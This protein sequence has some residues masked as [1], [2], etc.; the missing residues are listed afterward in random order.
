MWLK[1]L[2][3]NKW[4]L[5][6]LVAWVLVYFFVLPRVINVK[7]IVNKQNCEDELRI[8]GVELNGLVTAKFK[9]NR[10][11][12]FFKYF[13]GQDTLVSEWGLLNDD[14]YNNIEVGDSIRK[15]SGSL[16][17]Q[18]KGNGKDTTQVIDWDCN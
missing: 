15:G 2:I 8:K 16:L 5:I 10:G 13:N 17:F 4:F 6:I 9:D 1:K 12:Q 11:L 18:V 3:S 7:D 14:F